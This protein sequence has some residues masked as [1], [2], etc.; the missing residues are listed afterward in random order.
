MRVS[1]GVIFLMKK[2]IYNIE[3]TC[4]VERR[5]NSVQLIRDYHTSGVTAILVTYLNVS[6][7]QS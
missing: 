7:I 1:T 2:K 4:E 6:T 3:K 5:S